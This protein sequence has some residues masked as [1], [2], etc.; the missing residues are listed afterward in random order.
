MRANKVSNVVITVKRGAQNPIPA[1]GSALRRARVLLH[2]GLFLPRDRR[3]D[4][5][6]LTAVVVL[7][8]VVL[9]ADDSALAAAH[10]FVVVV[11]LVRLG[12]S[13]RW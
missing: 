9:L 5:A 7:L 3:G 2:H 4:A 11:I 8:V 12:R 1:W 10:P 6:A 13:L